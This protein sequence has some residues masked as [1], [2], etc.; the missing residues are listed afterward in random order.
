MSQQDMLASHVITWHTWLA[1]LLCGGKISTWNIQLSITLSNMV[2]FGSNECPRARGSRPRGA[3]RGT[4][5]DADSLPTPP[6]AG[7]FYRGLVWSESSDVELGK[8]LNIT[9]VICNSVFFI[10]SKEAYNF[11]RKSYRNFSA[12]SPAPNFGARGPRRRPA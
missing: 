1:G 8:K 12:E 7:P 5:P 11:R 6:S 4:R 3:S 9:W 10:L 2:R